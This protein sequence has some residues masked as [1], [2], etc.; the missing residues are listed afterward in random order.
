[1]NTELLYQF[2]D[3]VFMQS[4]PIIGGMVIAVTIVIYLIITVRDYL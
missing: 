3:S 2:I 4:L 1:M